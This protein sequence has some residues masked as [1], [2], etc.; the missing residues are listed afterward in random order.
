MLSFY[1]KFM[2]LAI[3]RR[4]YGSSY[5]SLRQSQQ[6]LKILETDIFL[7][8]DFVRIFQREIHWLKC[9]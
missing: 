8:Q 9:V 2:A 1:E 3:L 5:F 4:S 7:V 6:N